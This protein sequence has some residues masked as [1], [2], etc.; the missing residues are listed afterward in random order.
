[1]KTFILILTMIAD[2]GYDGQGGIAMIEFNSEQACITA[3]QKWQKQVTTP[4]GEG[5]LKFKLLDNNETFYLCVEK[6]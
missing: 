4:I 5:F 1:M 6:D 2:G 3:G